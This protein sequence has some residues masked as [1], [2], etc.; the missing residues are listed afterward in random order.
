MGKMPKY[1]NDEMSRRIDRII[2]SERDRNIL[3]RRLLDGIR[4]EPLAE[5]V[6]LSPQRV[7]AI[8]R[9]YKKTLFAGMA[10]R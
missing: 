2:H 8:V 10:E 4:F 5:E 9:E 7:R 3:K 6:G 1:N